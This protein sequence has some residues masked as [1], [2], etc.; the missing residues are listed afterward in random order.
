MNYGLPTITRSA[1]R[2]C[3]ATVAT[4]QPLQ[5]YASG[6]NANTEAT[7]PPF[8]LN[9]KAP[10]FI[11]R[12]QPGQPVQEHPGAAS[13]ILDRRAKAYQ[14]PSPVT[15]HQRASKSRPETAKRI[16]SA[17]DVLK[18]QD[19]IKAE[20][21]FQAILQ[22]DHNILNEFDHQRTVIGLARS[23]KEQTSEKKKEALTRLEELR[24]NGTFTES[25][26]ST[27]RHLD[28]TMSLCEQA[29]GWFLDAEARLLRLRNKK[30]DANEETL[31]QHSGYFD[32]DIANARLWQYMRKYQLAEKL[33][34]GMKAGLIN[35]LQSNPHTAVAEKLHNYLDCVN[36]ALARYWQEMCQ[37]DRAEELLLSMGGKHLD[38][39]IETLC[40]PS[41]HH[42]IDLVRHWQVMGKYEWAE[43]L[44]L[45]MSGKDSKD[46]IETLCTPSEHPEFNLALALLWQVTGRHQLSEKLLLNMIVKHP[47]DTEEILCTPSGKHEIDLAL[48][49]LWQEMGQYQRTERLLLNMSVKHPDENEETLCQPC[50][51]HDIDLTLVRLWQKLKKHRQAE[52]LLLKM[53][54]KRPDAAMEE[55]CR[56]CGNNDIDLALALHWEIKNKYHL[57][58]GLLLNMS[59]KHLNHS[60]D[61][62]CMPCG[63]HDV[64]LALVRL[65]E[66]ID[67]DKQAKRLIERCCDLYH[68][69]ECEL[70]YL[71][72]STGKTSFMEAINRYP[73]SA[74]KL[75]VISIHYFALACEQISEGSP[76]S[77]E[78]N[79]IKALEHVELTLERYPPTA[80]AYSQKAHC[81]RM[82]GADDQKWQKWFQKAHVLDSSRKQRGKS[83][84]WRSNEYAAL[85]KIMTQT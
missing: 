19:Y 74:N 60:E 73:E 17:F 69:D 21:A 15:F 70:S 4:S 34:L 72:L 41:G 64:D 43:K 54:G 27:I 39:S 2:S 65:W 22:D 37:Y 49:R 52:K 71:S 11:P 48:V 28:L 14:N 25:G 68:S 45:N 66:I 53:S 75:L 77:G 63:N 5:Y 35:K 85:Q 78:E 23:L 36:I 13:N 58:E 16:D 81:L 44:L 18:K 31:C 29:L 1:T 51:Q 55:L 83:D 32:A 79:L 10:A 20:A 40:K 46:S 76:K 8:K 80:G 47:D 82:M 62:L 9:P 57:T 30:P 61:S 33:L 56:P 67:K 24:V 38:E 42:D 3:T 26:A 59:N 7:K 6:S 12:V 50:G 84:A